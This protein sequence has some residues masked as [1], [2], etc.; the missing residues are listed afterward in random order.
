MA[1]HKTEAIVLKRKDYRET[2][3]LLSLF[4]ADFGKIYAQAKGARRK[5]GKFASN[6]LPIT[7]NK[8]VFYENQSGGLHI[9]SQADIIDHFGNIDTHIERFTYA[10]YF[11]E[12]V[13]AA[14]P[15]AEKNSEVFSL[16]MKFLQ[17]LD[18]ADTINNIAQIFE[19][20]FLNLSGFKPRVD[21]CVNCGGHIIAQSKF[22]F[23]LG[24][25]LCPQCCAA[26]HG[27]CPV[28]RG[29]IA[30]LKYIEKTE[31]EKI[32]NFRIGGTIRTELKQLLRNFIDFHLGQQ[33]KSI[34]FSKKMKVAYA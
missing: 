8:I 12:L 20:K 17:F 19:V 33:F 30:T 28:M 26:D 27:A 1:I 15:L 7:N 6:F 32:V 9:I 24:G 3:Y 10:A 11:L 14:M 29:T 18:K 5:I 2:S 4:T 25:L 13:N 23:V 16:V 22:S 21:C 31:L 34:Q